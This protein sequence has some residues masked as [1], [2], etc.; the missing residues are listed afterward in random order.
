MLK[1]WENED[2]L[3]SSVFYGNGE[4]SGVSCDNNSIDLI[5][6][7]CSLHDVTDIIQD[8]KERESIQ[9][10][11]KNICTTRDG[12][13]YYSKIATLTKENFNYMIESFPRKH[14][15]DAIPKKI[16]PMFY[17]MYRTNKIPDGVVPYKLD[18]S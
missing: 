7:V 16:I 8:R 6:L 11:F 3:I 2:P 12:Q 10:F 17:N 18:L 9:D 14:C 1:P 4:C 5:R 13:D 15:W